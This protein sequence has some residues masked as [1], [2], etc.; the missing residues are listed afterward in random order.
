MSKDFEKALNRAV[1]GAK[2]RNHVV[3]K[4]HH[5]WVSTDQIAEK[6]RT[7]F[8]SLSF[9][10]LEAE[11]IHGVNSIVTGVCEK[12]KLL[13]PM[14]LGNLWRG[15]TKYG[16]HEC[17]WEGGGDVDYSSRFKNHHG[18][19]GQSGL[20]FDLFMKTKQIFPDATPGHRIQGRKEID[21]WVPSISCGIEYNGNYY[22]V[23]AMGRGKEYHS[24]KTNI[25]AKQGKFI[26]H[27][28]SDEAQDSDKLVRLLQLF[29]DMLHMAE[30]G[31][32]KGMAVNAQVV[33]ASIA[34]QFHNQWNFTYGPND[35][36][37]DLHVGVFDV[38]FNM[39]GALS[40]NRKAGVVTKVSISKPCVPISP[41]IQWLSN[42]FKLPGLSVSCD[43]R[44]PIE[45]LTCRFDS[46]LSWCFELEPSPLLFD[47]QYR[48]IRE[49]LPDYMGISAYTNKNIET[50]RHS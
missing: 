1:E 31:T 10:W 2:C 50:N 48:M 3:N 16:C 34:E 41:I 6:L 43:R 35:F 18:Y 20:E 36:A 8:S 22:H 45:W 19:V 47:K 14:H 11:H 4:E 5:N 24:G 23:E 49:A 42:G 27:V 13:V 29:G 28:F 39:I 21:I 7:E 9:P 33:S 40:V 26:F 44:N 15:T 32:I 38:N 46:G 17:A 30:S 12:H 37:N 25:A